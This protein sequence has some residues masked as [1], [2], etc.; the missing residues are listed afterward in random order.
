M[1]ELVFFLNKN[2]RVKLEQFRDLLGRLCT[3]ES[4]PNDAEKITNLHLAYYK[5]DTT[6]VTKIKQN[7]KTMWVYAKNMDKDKTN[8]DILIHTS[9]NYKVPVARLDCW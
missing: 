5:H 3:G 8:L 1:T 9:K 4:T 2:Y 7:Q 6:F